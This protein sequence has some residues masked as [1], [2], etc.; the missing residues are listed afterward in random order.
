MFSAMVRTAPRTVK[1]SVVAKPSGYADFAVLWG[2]T[3]PH[4]LQDAARQ[5]EAGG[6][7]I[8]LDL[9]YFSRDKPDPMIRVS[10]DHGHP[11]RLFDS[12][13]SDDTRLRELPV[14][15]WDGYQRDGHV[16]VVGLGDKSRSKDLRYWE[17]DVTE[18]LREEFPDRELV[19]RPKF[20]SSVRN[21]DGLITRADLDVRDVL[22]G[23][24]LVVCVHSNVAIDAVCA[25]VPFR[26]SDGAAYWLS[27]KEY[28]L[29]NRVLFLRKLSYWQWRP[30]EAASMWKFLL[31]MLQL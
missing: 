16:V 2:L 26:C 4:S 14:S 18:K 31:E 29:E 19:Y 1:V 11:W 21:I 24:S 3:A 17:R 9:G 13:P 7:I 28:S 27:D 23:A 8:C 6:R 25:G 12:T 30:S 22:K 10:I 15:I 5:T 20:K